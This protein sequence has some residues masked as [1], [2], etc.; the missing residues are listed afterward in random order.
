VPN[1]VCGRALVR[2]DEGDGAHDLPRRAEAALHRIGAHERIDH[3]MVAQ[4]LDRRHAPTGDAVG[5]RDARKCRLAVDEHRARAAVTLVARDLRPR[6]A[7][8]LAQELCE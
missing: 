2:L 3:R 7:D 6:Q 4:A 5:E 8:V 1:F